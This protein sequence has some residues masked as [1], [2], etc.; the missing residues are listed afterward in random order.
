MNI[1]GIVLILISVCLFFY[2][3]PWINCYQTFVTSVPLITIILASICSIS[4]IV[5]NI[6][7][8]SRHLDAEAEGKRYKTY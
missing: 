6:R 3:M 1:L 2:W 8:A 7:N 5:M 4:F